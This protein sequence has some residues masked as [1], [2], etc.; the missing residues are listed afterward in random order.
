MK[1]EV[2]TSVKSEIE[3][4]T[5]TLKD[6]LGNEIANQLTE[7]TTL[8]KEEKDLIKSALKENDVK[9]KEF[10]KAKSGTL[11]IELKANQNSSDVAD[12]DDYALI[13]QGTNRKPFRKFSISDLFRRTP[14]SKEYVKYREENTITR[15]AKVVV[16]CASS[17]HNTKKTWINRTVQITKIR[18]MVDVC[19]D[20]LDDYDFVSAE[21]RQLVEES[22][23]AKEESEILLGTGTTSDDIL[24]I[25]TIASEFSASNSL[26]PFNGVNGFQSPTLAEL[27]AA[28]SAQIVT[29]GQENK[30]IPD[31]IL[32][33]YNDKVRFM[34]Q[35]NLDNDY[36]LPNFVLTNGGILNGM[37][38]ITSPLVAPNTLYVIDSTRG[39]ILD[40]KQ[41]NVEFYYENKDNAE[42]EIV[43]IK[44]VERVQ[45]HVPFID[46][47]AF[48]KCSDI[49]LALSAISKP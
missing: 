8:G 27:T 23:K 7:K 46:R 6:F 33:N 49:N 34:H 45:F 39:Q 13:L 14:V 5:Q 48:M 4:A 1:N 15:D 32:M 3:T 17:T 9:I 28:M 44:A 11:E 19:V 42:K 25:N 16:A 40:R 2:T 37:K 36:L 31:V 35:K 30:W 26:A 24:S 12:R 21:I 10:L 43:T 41:M 20:M 38:I 18:D 29:F 47:N 22:L